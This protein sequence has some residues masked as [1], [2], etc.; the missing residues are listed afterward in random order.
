MSDPAV[1][2]FV[3]MQFEGLQALL[4]WCKVLRVGNE[5][6]IYCPNEKMAQLLKRLA[7]NKGKELNFSIAI[8][9]EA[10]D[11]VRNQQREIAPTKSVRDPSI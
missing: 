7:I 10:A 2:K 6:Q 9:V 11:R 1:V 3:S 5:I 4:H 8:L